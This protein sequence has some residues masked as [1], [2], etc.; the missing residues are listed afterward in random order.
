MAVARAARTSGGHIVPGEEPGKSGGWP[1]AIKEATRLG[2]PVGF[3]FMFK[4]WVM[5]ISC[6]GGDG[7]GV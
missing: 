7:G 4:P 2:L 6:E 1:H 3:S 5:M